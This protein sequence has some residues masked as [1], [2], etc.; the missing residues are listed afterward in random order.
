[1]A[2]CTAISSVRALVV[3]ILGTLLL[4]GAVIAYALANA[5]AEDPDMSQYRSADAGPQ[6]LRFKQTG[7]VHVHAPGRI[8]DVEDGQAPGRIG[9]EDDMV[10]GDVGGKQ[11]QTTTNLMESV[12]PVVSILWT[13]V[14][15]GI[16]LN[17]LLLW[18][19]AR[20]RLSSGGSSREL[21][22]EL[23]LSSAEDE[24]WRV[25]QSHFLAGWNMAPLCLLILS[26]YRIWSFVATNAG[27]HREH[28]ASQE[29][30]CDA[31]FTR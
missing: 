1:M 24:Q 14:L 19:Y 26:G 31:F 8:D 4:W 30:S 27:Q 25:Q 13:A 9:D 22:R 3:G 23:S 2:F 11:Q 7:V 15:I 6:G 5:N 17:L 18:L 28:S 20:S 12:L 21:V 29:P 16:L 10:G